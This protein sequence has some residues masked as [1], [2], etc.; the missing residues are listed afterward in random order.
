MVAM[1]IVGSGDVDVQVSVEQD[2]HQIRGRHRRC[3]MPRAC[4]GAGTYGIHPQLLGEF[5]TKV[6]SRG[7]VH[8][9]PTHGDR[10]P[11]T[12]G[13]P[14]ARRRVVSRP[15]TACVNRRVCGYADAVWWQWLT[16]I[17]ATIL[18][19]AFVAYSVWKLLCVPSPDAPNDG[20]IG[21]GSGGSFRPIH[22]TPS[23]T[24]PSTGLRG[25][26][27]SGPICAGHRPH[28]SGPPASPA[29]DRNR[30]VSRSSALS[31]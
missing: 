27:R 19:P 17:A 18:L 30:R 21:T 26:R 2:G 29:K 9:V 4:G 3:R 11:P 28:C 16:M 13:R 20:G 8:G 25:R 6:G 12:A 23:G 7:H 1:W 5:T 10:K 31:C 22:P 15:L 24:G 14:G